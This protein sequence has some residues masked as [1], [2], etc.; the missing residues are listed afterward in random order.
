MAFSATADGPPFSSWVAKV[1]HG[2][3]IVV[4]G[5]AG[6]VGTVL[7]QLARHAGIDVIGTAGPKQQDRL[8]ELGAT[9]I[10]YRSEDVFARVRELAPGGVAAVFDHVGGDGIKD[11]WRMLAR[12][13]TL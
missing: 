2:Q 11:S 4:R 12:G 13:G 6:G 5:A 9:P 8:R 3:T 7:V 10:D 1:R